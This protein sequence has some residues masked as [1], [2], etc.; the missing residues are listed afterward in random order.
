M[1][2][3]TYTGRHFDC[4]DP[5][6]STVHIMDIARALSREKRFANQTQVGYSVAQHSLVVERIVARTVG[7]PQISRSIRM[8]ALLHDA[9]EAYLRD[10]PLP[11][12]A[13]LETLA[14]GALRQLKARFQGAIEA[15]FHVDCTPAE[16]W[17]IRQADLQALKV[18]KQDL[19]IDPLCE[20]PVLDGVVRPH[21]IDP[22]QPMGE[23]A[24]MLAFVQRFMELQA[25]AEP[26]AQRQ[27]QPA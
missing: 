25:E 9:H 8:A 22:L 27:G 15:R 24:A 12:E 14:P 17:R 5:C 13:A 23:D 21:F 18:E 20:W 11:V 19:R 6:P 26:Q 10:I 16:H 4:L 2:I 1:Y 3:S 7:T